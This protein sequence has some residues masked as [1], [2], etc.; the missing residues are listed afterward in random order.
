[1]RAQTE[2]H[3]HREQPV[4][5]H[6]GRGPPVVPDWLKARTSALVAVV[7]AS[8]GCPRVEYKCNFH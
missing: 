3:A 2:S 7:V 8:Q 6:V 1:M 4:A 5:D